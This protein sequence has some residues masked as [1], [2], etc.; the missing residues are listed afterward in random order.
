MTPDGRSRH[1]THRRHKQETHAAARS[2]ALP[3][4]P[5]PATRKNAPGRQ[6]ARLPMAH[7]TPKR[8]QDAITPT[9]ARAPPAAHAA[10]GGCPNAASPPAQR[11]SL[12]HTPVPHSTPWLTSPAVAS[13]SKKMKPL[14][15]IIR[16]QPSRTPLGDITNSNDVLLDSVLNSAV[17]RYAAIRDA[18]RSFLGGT[19]VTRA[20]LLF[21]SSKCHGLVVPLI[22]CVLSARPCYLVI[23]CRQDATLIQRHGKGRQCHFSHEDLGHPLSSSALLVLCGNAIAQGIADSRPS[24]AA[25]LGPWKSHSAVNFN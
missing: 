11:T 1:V 16:S 6:P 15:T 14:R 7:G 21:S 5:T 17:R 22:Y 10:S 8:R 3:L 18:G 20:L 9:G 24:E 25:R 4:S 13:R 2:P 23:M 12:R 19:T